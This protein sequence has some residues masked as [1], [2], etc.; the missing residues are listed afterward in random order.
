MSD[1]FTTLPAMTEL[2]QNLETWSANNP[3]EQ[4]EFAKQLAVGLTDPSKASI[5]SLIDIPGEF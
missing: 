5:W 1:L 2:S 4:G 3:G